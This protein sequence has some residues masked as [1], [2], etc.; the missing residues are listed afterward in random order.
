V[1]SV[2]SSEISSTQCGVLP[3]CGLFFCPVAVCVLVLASRG[4]WRGYL[5]LRSQENC[6]SFP[7]RSSGEARAARHADISR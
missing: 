2:T 6:P 4:N 5:V 1:T 3:M 7:D